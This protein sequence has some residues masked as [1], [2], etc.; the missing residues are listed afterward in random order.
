MNE[1][2]FQVKSPL[3]PQKVKQLPHDSL[4]PFLHHTQE[5][6]KHTSTQKF[7]YECVYSSIIHNNKKLETSKCPSTCDGIKKSGIYTMQYYLTIKEWST[8]SC[9]TVDE[10]WKHYAKKSVV[11]KLYFMHP[12]C[13]KCLEQA[14]LKKQKVEKWLSVAGR[15]EEWGMTVSGYRVSS[16]RTETVPELVVIAQ[17]CEYTEKIT[18]YFKRAN[19]VVCELNFY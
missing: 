14:N 18:V 2:Q 8:D 12:I 4:I 1:T 19:C 6:Q 17:L 5:N 11:K 3:P 10:L 7:V 9:S 16:L 15:R 13:L